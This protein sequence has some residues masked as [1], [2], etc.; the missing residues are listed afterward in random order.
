M[1]VIEF[2]GHSDDTFGYDVLGPGGKRIDG[3]DHDDC[4]NMKVRTFEV[5]SEETETGIFVIGVYSKC[6]EAV[7]AVG[8]A[9][10]DEGVAIPD[11]AARP[12]FRTENYTPVL[13]LEAPDDAV[14]TLVCVDGKEPK[15]D[16]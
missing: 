6:P 8:L 1:K 2:K 14:V 15:E 9:P 11:W 5:W 12:E 10:L 4:A 13:R 3:D 7:W 16:D